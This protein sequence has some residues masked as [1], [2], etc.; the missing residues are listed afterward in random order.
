VVPDLRRDTLRRT[1]VVVTAAIGL[2]ISALW[3][4]VEWAGW[5]FISDE[6]YVAYQDSIGD[7]AV[8]GLGALLGGAL[9]TRL[10]FD[11]ADALPR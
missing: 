1:P 10:S 4:M 3:E 8:G 5:R 2:A 6:I 7:M 11:R 9:L